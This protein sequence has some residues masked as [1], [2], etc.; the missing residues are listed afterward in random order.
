MSTLISKYATR[1]LK[2]RV[3]EIEVRAHC[4]LANGER[5]AVRLVASS[6]GGKP[7]TPKLCM[8]TPK[9]HASRTCHYRRY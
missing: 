9:L 4:N 3:D 5:Q 8:Q 6:M 1:L 2:L 7:R